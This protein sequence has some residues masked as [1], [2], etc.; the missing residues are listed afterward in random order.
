LHL[1]L[2]EHAEAEAWAVV[3][4]KQR[5]NPRIIHPDPDAIA[6]DARLRYLQDRAADLVAIANAHLVVA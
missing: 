4:D 6:G 2:V 3:G 5:R 1:A